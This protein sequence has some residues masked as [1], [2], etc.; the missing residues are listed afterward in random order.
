MGN[1]NIG[2]V[3]L[4]A[5]ISIVDSGAILATD[6]S[7]FV[8]DWRSVSID[9][10]WSPTT[11]CNAVS[12]T[13]RHLVLEPV[14]DDPSSVR[15]EW[16]RV[17]VARW[18]LATQSCRWP[19]DSEF[20]PLYTI[21]TNWELVGH[22]DASRGVLSLHGKYVT[23]KGERCDTLKPAD[24]ADFDTELQFDNGRLTDT[25]A[26]AKTDDDIPFISASTEADRKRAVADAVRRVVRAFDDDPAS[27]YA[28][29]ISDHAKKTFG[30]EQAVALLRRF[31]EQLGRPL[32]RSP[33]DTV[34]AI[35]YPAYESGSGEYAIVMNSVYLPSNRTAVEMFILVRERDAWKVEM[36]S[37][38]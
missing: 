37:W 36:F 18:A 21:L 38:T 31:H 35:R 3:V 6:A 17:R 2:A 10:G 33:L 8:G 4:A 23:C 27:F 34:Y 19:G 11:G 12:T 1:R 7:S 14:L 25:N 30:R 29:W 13:D 15:G 22:I 20:K 26:T 9:G 16:V 5:V 32:S 24:K 28:D